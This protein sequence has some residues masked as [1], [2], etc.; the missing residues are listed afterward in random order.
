MNVSA[1]HAVEIK[2][3]EKFKQIS[4]P[5]QRVQK[6]V[7]YESDSDINHNLSTQNNLQESR[8]ENEHLEI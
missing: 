1:N 2:E 5:S 7:E 3:S 6:L 8:K 4:G